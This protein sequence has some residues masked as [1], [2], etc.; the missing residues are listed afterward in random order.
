MGF[1]KS[2][3][4]FAAAIAAGIFGGPALA[5]H[6]SWPD[7]RADSW[8]YVVVP[9]HEGNVVGY[10]TAQP[11]PYY[12]SY[13]PAPRYHYYYE[14]V[15]RAYYREPAPPALVYYYGDPSPFPHSNARD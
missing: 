9:R 7:S 1:P 11:S 6:R 4:V 5:D 10:V 14:T 3:I 13:E 8:S 12:Y 2:T 15:P